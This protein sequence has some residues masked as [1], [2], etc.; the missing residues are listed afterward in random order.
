MLAVE[1]RGLPIGLTITSATP[2]ESKLI[3]P[4][5]NTIR[6]PRAGAGRPR[7]R[8][9]R[10]IYDRAA[11]SLKLRRRLLEERNVDLICPHRK[12]CK[13]KVQD[14]R[15][16]RRYEDRWTVERTNAW[17]QNYRR[18]AT[19]FDRLIS[20]YTAFVILACIMIVLKRL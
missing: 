18:V 9:K 5:L 1:G 20:S 19:R 12:N 2:H 7:T 8:I 13:H 14:G 3:E 15:K 16:L 10:L 6:V 4:L 11:D 17:L